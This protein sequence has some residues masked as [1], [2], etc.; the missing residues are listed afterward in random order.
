MKV[1]FE[2]PFGTI[3]AYNIMYEQYKIQLSA[4]H[5]GRNNNAKRSPDV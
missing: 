4:Y 2:L 5:H 1:Y 3:F